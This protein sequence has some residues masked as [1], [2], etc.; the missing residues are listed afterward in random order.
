MIRRY[1]ADEA[2]DKSA[3]GDAKTVI[4]IP[5]IGTVVLR[6]VSALLTGETVIVGATT[7]R[8]TRVTGPQTWWKIWRASGTA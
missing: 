1:A 2:A 3:M 7:Y 4:A 5:I 8:A 6:M